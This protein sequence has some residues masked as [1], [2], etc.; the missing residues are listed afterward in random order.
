MARP[1]KEFIRLTGRVIAEGGSTEE[2]VEFVKRK[3]KMMDQA[4]LVRQAISIYHKYE[5]GQLFNE[6]MEGIIAQLINTLK[7]MDRKE[8]NAILSSEEAVVDESVN[9]NLSEKEMELKRKL[10]ASA[11]GGFGLLKEE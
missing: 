5:T 9:E 8:V 4:T 11:L 3:L 7:K 6:K 10:A 1:R 2:E